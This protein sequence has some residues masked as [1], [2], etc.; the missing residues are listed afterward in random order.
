MS[1]RITHITKIE[2]VFEEFH[3][4]VCNDLCVDILVECCSRYDSLSCALI[5]RALGSPR[6]AYFFALMLSDLVA[7]EAGATSESV[8]WLG[9]VFIGKYGFLT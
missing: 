8:L 5:T 2:A 9:R 3:F 4:E 7:F 1:V 6:S